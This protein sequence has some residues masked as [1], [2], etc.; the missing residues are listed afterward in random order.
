MVV[1]LPLEKGYFL[2][3]WVAIHTNAKAY[4]PL[5]GWAVSQIFL[6]WCFFNTRIPVRIFSFG[7]RWFQE[8][9]IL[10]L[11]VGFVHLREKPT[12]STS[13]QF[14]YTG[15][16]AITPGPGI[17]SNASCW[18]GLQAGEILLGFFF[19]ILKQPVVWTNSCNPLQ[20]S[21]GF[22]FW[23]RA[24]AKTFYENPCH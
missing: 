8:V 16:A 3:S 7:T 10:I 21:T 1:L 6:V 2:S 4:H 14:I 17:L 13:S 5:L 24:E 19:T 15:I 22:I 11:L 9:H 12:S 18:S 23:S 20:G